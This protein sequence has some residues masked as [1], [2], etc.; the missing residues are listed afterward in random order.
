VTSRLENAVFAIQ[1]EFQ[2]I[3]T[4]NGFRNDL[5]VGQV[6]VGI[7]HPSVITD[8]PEI[9]IESVKC[10]T[11]PIDD[12][13]TIY[14]A[15]A[16][17]HVYARLKPNVDLTNEPTK[18]NEAVESMAHDMSVVMA[19]MTKKYVVDSTSPWIVG[20]EGKFTITRYRSQT[21]TSIGRCEVV[22]KFQILLR[23]ITQT[24]A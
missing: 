20:D 9:G 19:T 22:L 4:A 11:M 13:R 14:N 12:A 17:I 15:L 2:R 18:L 7:R 16:D 3:T 6:L 10:V 1:D 5:A 21:Q 8:F 23:N 24:F